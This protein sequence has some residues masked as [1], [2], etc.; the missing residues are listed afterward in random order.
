VSIQSGSIE[1]ITTLLDFGAQPNFY[2]GIAFNP[3]INDLRTSRGMLW[4][5]TIRL[6][7]PQSD[8]VI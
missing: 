3:S 1:S 5:L 6:S 8:L 4:R 7:L 2:A